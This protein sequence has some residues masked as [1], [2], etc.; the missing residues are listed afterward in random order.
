MKRALV[1]SLAISLALGAGNALAVGL[2]QIQVKSRLNQP[3]V[4]E[5][6]VTVDR[7]SD[8]ESLVVGL[9]S[10]E[11][12]SRIGIERSQIGVPLEF[13]LV[14]GGNGQAVIRVTSTEPVRAPFLDF[15][16]A[17]N[18]GTGRVLREYTVLLDPPTTAP[19]VAAVEEPAQVERQTA[20]EPPPPEPVRIA[21][22]AEPPAPVATTQAESPAP[23]RAPLPVP[24]PPAAP[25]AVAPV[26][27]VPKATAEPARQAVR[28]APAQLV[29]P[30]P[31]SLA[32]SSGTSYG[33]VS[34]GETLG[35]IA[36]ATLPDD[37]VSTNQLMLALLNANPQAFSDNNINR[38][39]RGAILR[40]P[41]PE[42]MRAV[43]STREAAAQVRAQ[44]ETWRGEPTAPTLLTGS[45]AG[46][47]GK[48]DF[49]TAT[50]GPTGDDRLA[51]VPPEMGK[52]GL[53]STGQAGSSA[54]TARGNATAADLARDNEELQSRKQ[55]AGE[56]R[57]RVTDLEKIQTSNERLIS[58]K[59]SEIADLQ[60]K[61]ASAQADAEAQATAA[62]KAAATAKAEAAEQATA[63]AQAAAAEQA[64]ATAKAA[65]A[66]EAIATAQTA[67]AEQAAASQST[68]TAAEATPS[69]A[70]V[71]DT[72][73]ETPPAETAVTP[74]EDIWSKDGNEVAPSTDVT[75]VESPPVSGAPEGLTDAAGAES[76]NPQATELDTSAVETQP[77]VGSETTTVVDTTAP[78]ENPGAVDQSVITPMDPVLEETP[79]YLDPRV[80][81]GAA[82]I[83][84]LLGFLAIRS[85]RNTPVVVAKPSIADRFGAATTLTPVGAGPID[86]AVG[87]VDEERQMAEQIA[88]DP[89]DLGAR[90]ELLSI[91]YADNRVD[92]FR[93]AA[94]AME[95]YVDDPK[96]PEWVQV[97][98]MGEDLLPNDPLFSAVVVAQAA[99]PHDDW[100]AVGDTPADDGVRWSDDLEGTD[101]VDVDRSGFVD[102]DAVVI[103]DDVVEAPVADAAYSESRFAPAP[104]IDIEP[105]YQHVL[106]DDELLLDVEPPALLDDPFDELDADAMDARAAGGLDFTLED[107]PELEEGTLLPSAST[108]F[109]PDRPSLSGRPL[110]EMSMDD[111]P[112]AENFGFELPPLEFESS[113]GEVTTAVDV[114]QRGDEHFDDDRP[115]DLAAPDHDDEFLTGEDA[116]GTKLDLA[117]AYVDMG[118]PDGARGML[119][120]VISAGDSAQQDE[121][122]RLL[123]EL[124]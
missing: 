21:P 102:T 80:L 18:W 69:A 32:S 77:Q 59:D 13:V 6:P 87:V 123:A 29:K 109:L 104:V 1:L 72:L 23:V 100:S 110:T 17:A 30:M 112:P 8:A 114:P 51:L 113:F 45:A 91:Y 118:D 116:L 117:R 124:D 74:Q 121:A 66:E 44:V 53:A 41:S 24:E 119:E 20:V 62:E 94:L 63:T 54:G 107:A 48:A 96:E 4:A 5:I 14:K 15:L 34:A 11:E 36:R 76:T 84:L 95:P 10:A 90:L 97:R 39:K 31:S 71:E 2:G 120:E 33:P 26:R 46:N 61:L 37:G 64:A 7:G 68:N 88:E 3:L 57:S 27:S 73:A 115:N 108:T 106:T 83:A 105:A 86:D 38:L 98:A 93:A 19:A 82:L 78:V 55:E 35:Q 52:D 111:H 42:E 81:G 92:E 67:A 70:P 103:V 49:S 85:R 43:G 99:A 56:L 9:A 65:A 12:F 89:A 58:L 40:I 22:V 75:P 79:W 16:I 122:R 47:V 101:D 60:R 28:P 25:I 50:S